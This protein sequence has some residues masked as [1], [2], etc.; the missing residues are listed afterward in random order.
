MGL[1][2]SVAT[3][4]ILFHSKDKYVHECGRPSFMRPAA[5]MP[6]EMKAKVRFT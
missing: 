5:G 2:K 6:P 4:E 1:Y 3:G